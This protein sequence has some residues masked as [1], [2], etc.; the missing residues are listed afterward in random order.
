MKKIAGAVCTALLAIG[1][2][3]TPALAADV[4][5]TL[6]TF[7]VT[8]NGVTMEQSKNQYPMLVYKDITYV[9]MTWADTRLLGLESNWTKQNGLVIGKASTVQDQ[10]TA[11]S[12]YQPYKSSAANKNS[13]QATTASG[14]I[15]VN[16]KS[17][18][19]SSEQYPLLVFRDVTYFPLTWRFAVNEFGWDYSFDQKKGLVV[20][21][22]V[23]MNSTGN[24]VINNSG[25]VGQKVTVTG[26]D[27]NLRADAG[28]DSASKGLVQRGT[29]LIVL[30]S[31]TVSG[32]EWYQVERVDNGEKAW[33][34]SWLTEKSTNNS[35]ST[36]TGSNNS[37][38]N[39][40]SNNASSNSSA[41]DA[42]VGKTIT[43]TGS[44]VNLRANTSTTSA[45]LGQAAKGD[46]FTVLAAKTADGDT[47][48]QVQMKNGAKAWIAGWLTKEGTDTSTNNSE[49]NDDKNNNNNSSNNNNSN[50][51]VIENYDIVGKKVTVI[52]SGV[53]LRKEP[54]TNA[55]S[56]GTVAKGTELTVLT[57]KT[58]DG[59]QW[60]QVKDTSGNKVWIASWLT[61]QA[62]MNG[63]IAG[64][65]KLVL[66]SVQQQ[67]SKTIVLLKHGKGN[68]Y[69]TGKATDTELV[70]Q[71]KNNYMS[72][73]EKINQSFDDGPLRQLVVQ[74]DGSGTLKAIFT[75]QKGAYCTVKESGDN[76]VITAYNQHEA[77]EQG[78]AG[79][80]IVID[81]GHGGS[82]PGA[83]GKVQGVTDANV[84]LTV[85]QKLRD[86]LEAQ[87]AKVI[88]TRDTDIRV[89][90][91]D[92][93]AVAN[94]AEADLFVSI[95]AN[96]STKSAPNGIEIYYYAP[97]TN[98]NLYA[99]NYVRKELATQVSNSMQSATGTKSV[100]KTANYAVLRENDRPSILV[101]TGYLSNAAEEALLASDSYRQKLAS[102]IFEGIKNY[103]NQF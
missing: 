21:P 28:T 95:H 100:V 30:D 6:P 80:T 76:L 73:S 41:A 26:S 71:L 11:Q 67:G 16:G 10:K 60:Y 55:A 40:N 15:T 44:N 2:Y 63:N 27:V 93:P 20:A 37:N 62:G 56:V 53:N 42:M 81:P 23:I 78:L 58:V 38:S 39:N 72:A 103:L 88:M 87:G 68:E 9:P 90:L 59:E 79:K 66:Q 65:T 24:T 98:A 54:G 19:N 64:Q 13:Y 12:S 32:K 85:G 3:T 34:A 49:Q 77:G 70:L 84:G 94:Q 36:S 52:V 69:S 17:I 31:K 33:I 35:V 74:D 7:P 91:N 22:K 96:S 48:Y 4:T 97:S 89:G 14:K 47:W 46:T 5:V 83:I 75:L 92:R 50:N 99:Q 8:L 61:D 101:E 18:T 1:I 102:G 29:E 45:V 25:M 57:L 86:M 82:D 51:A 43:V